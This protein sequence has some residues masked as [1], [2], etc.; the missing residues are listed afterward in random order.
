MQGVNPKPQI[1]TEWLKDDGIFPNNPFL[2]LIIYR[3]AFLFSHGGSPE[4][5]ERTFAENSWTG[6]WRNGLY[7]VHHYHSTAHEVLGIYAGNVRIQFGG[8]K[9]PVHV[10]TPGDMIVVPAGVAHKNLQSS[11]DFRVVGA[12]PSGQSWDMNYGKEGERPDSD[13]NIEQVPRP[14]RDPL[15]GSSGPLIENWN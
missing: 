13:R 11:H 6:G 7:P 1:I 5:I 14:E 3:K 4:L 10:A 8:K 9:G 15:F 2:P 12:Y